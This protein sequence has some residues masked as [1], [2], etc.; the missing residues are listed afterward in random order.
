MRLLIICH[1]SIYSPS[2]QTYLPNATLI[3]LIQ[4]CIVNLETLSNQL[5]L[6][7][8]ILRGPP[9]KWSSTTYRTLGQA[10][11]RIASVGVGVRGLHGRIEAIQLNQVVCKFALLKSAL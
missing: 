7:A 8:E 9:S 5:S 2:R 6:S 1:N 10:A 4:L 3:T 11:R